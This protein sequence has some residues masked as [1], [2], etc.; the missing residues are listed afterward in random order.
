MSHRRKGVRLELFVGL[1]VGMVLGFATLALVASFVVVRAASSTT[2]PASRSGDPGGLQA[3]DR[4][5][6]SITASEAGFRSPAHLPGAAAGELGDLADA[7]TQETG[8]QR[9]KCRL[10]ASMRRAFGAALKISAGK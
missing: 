5:G 8:A 9:R 1:V 4:H 3:L 7:M 6:D 2:V 10:C